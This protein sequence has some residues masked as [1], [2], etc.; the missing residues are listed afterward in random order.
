MNERKKILWLVSWYP[1]KYDAFDGDFI[2]RHAKAAAL[3]DDIQVLFVKPHESQVEVE[4]KERSDGGLHEQIIYLPKQKGIAGKWKAYRQWWRFYQASV[5]AI[6][7]QQKPDLVH[8]H[9]PWRAG[10]VALWIK[11]KIK[12]DY[13]VTEHWGIYNKVVDDNIHTKS[14]LLRRVLRSIFINAKDFASVSRYVG[15]GVKSA[16]FNKAY[17]VIPNVVDTSLFYPSQTKYSRFCFLHVSNMVPLKNVGDIINAFHRFLQATGADAQLLLIGNRDEQYHRLA[18]SLELLNRSVF[19]RG[20]ISYEE[21]AKE[22][23]H[24]HVL[25]VNSAMENSPCVIGEALCCGLPVIATRVGGIP[26]L[27]NERN[28]S[29]ISPGN[30]SELSGAMADMFR[31]IHQYNANDIATEAQQKFSPS[32][33]AKQFQLLYQAAV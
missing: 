9:V 6:I 24:S 31:S 8:V 25:V 29:L 17:S 18:Q 26:E 2:Q 27:I 32:V 22:M 1:N 11:R 14:F 28:G 12:I 15:E 7:R 20:E 21:V 19:F 3:H 10:L 16:V 30:T 33:V 5:N 13:V 4:K 23:Q